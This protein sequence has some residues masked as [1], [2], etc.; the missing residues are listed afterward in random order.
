VA[1][2]AQLKEIQSLDI[3]SKIASLERS[4]HEN[5]RNSVRQLRETVL[6][7]EAELSDVTKSTREKATV[8]QVEELEHRIAPKADKSHA[9][10]LQDN[11]AAMQTSLSSTLEEKVTRIEQALS[12]KA[13]VEQV[14]SLADRVEE[15]V[16]SIGKDLQTVY[17]VSKQHGFAMKGTEEQMEHMESSLQEKA[18]NS[19]L[20]Q[21]IGSHSSLQA[22]VSDLQDGLKEKV[23]LTKMNS[24]TMA[25][26]IQMTQIENSLQQKVDL[27]TIQQL[28]CIASGFDMKVN[29][30]AQD[31]QSGANHM[32]LFEGSMARLEKQLLEVRE[33]KAGLNK[34]QM[35]EDSLEGI[36]IK[37]KGIDSKVQSKP[38]AEQLREFQ[39][40]MSRS[41]SQVEAQLSKVDA[42]LHIGAA[43]LPH[44]ENSMA[45]IR[46][47][48]ASLEQSSLAKADRR[49]VQAFE[50]SMEKVEA[51]IAKLEQQ[52]NYGASRLQH[53]ED[54]VV[55]RRGPDVSSR[56]FQG[57]PQAGVHVG[58]GFM[59][60]GV[61]EA[62]A[63]KKQGVDRDHA[64]NSVGTPYAENPFRGSRRS[65]D[66]YGPY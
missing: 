30:L 21:F 6:K 64:S 7:L 27:E 3:S 50:N 25:W 61:K 42:L 22:Q 8:L 38:S 11:L 37:M 1:M 29:T 16:T 45:S 41:M 12:Q 20:E 63:N 51:G 35:V 17:D 59:T 46:A 34:L 52:A 39:R 5:D 60:R 2:R 24:T 23:C 4:A 31:L 33:E 55:Y 43:K 58:D 49:T 54:Q 18:A 26:Q 57:D 62:F 9:D 32:Q 13:N 15:E 40:S 19:Q 44:L 28:S 14:R 66:G 10:G 56:S 47:Q 48:V 53:L 36:E 65:N